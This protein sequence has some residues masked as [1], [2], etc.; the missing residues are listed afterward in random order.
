MLCAN[1][2]LWACA[3]GGLA[4]ST[5]ADRKDC[6]GANPVIWDVGNIEFTGNNRPWRPNPNPWGLGDIDWDAPREGRLEF[7]L[8]NREIISSR[9]TIC[10]FVGPSLQPNHAHNLT[11]ESWTDCVVINAELPSDVLTSF[12]FEVLTGRLEVKQ[13]W[14]C[15]DDIRDTVTFVGSTVLSFGNCTTD[16]FGGAFSRGYSLVSCTSENTTIH[17]FSSEPPAASRLAIAAREPLQSSPEKC[18]T[19]PPTWEIRNAEHNTWN[20]HSI[21]FLNLDVP[22]G[23]VL[24]LILNNI[25]IGHREWCFVEYD[26]AKNDAFDSWRLCNTRFVNSTAP[27]PVQSQIKFS[28]ETEH[29]GIKQTWFCTDEESQEVIKKTAFG[30]T[31]LKG[32]CAVHNLRLLQGNFSV[33][34]QC[35]FKYTVVKGFL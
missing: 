22:Y 7:D 8:I 15:T 16:V 35:D 19:D 33:L 18:I 13:E 25:A 23:S 30:E 9:R 4:A 32:N 27:W 10:E 14:S 31:D 21:D 17:G 28:N 34:F 3:I 11:N 1:L 2:L 12:R 24:T 6:P 20:V 5:E 26:G 29:L